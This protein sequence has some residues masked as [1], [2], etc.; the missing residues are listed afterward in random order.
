MNRSLNIPYKSRPQI[1]D[2][3]EITTWVWE[4]DKTNRLFN[5]SEGFVKMAEKTNVI[6]SAVVLKDGVSR[7]IFKK[8]SDMPSK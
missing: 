2:K 4:H 8:P 7:V 5:F 3:L 6:G 1:L